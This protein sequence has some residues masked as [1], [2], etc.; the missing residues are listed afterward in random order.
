MSLFVRDEGLGA[1]GEASLEMR[2]D[3]AVVWLTGW[4]PAGLE[5]LARS[6]VRD[7]LES[8]ASLDLRDFNAFIESGRTLVLEGDV[9]LE[10]EVRRG[11][12]FLLRYGLRNSFFY[13]DERLW[14]RPEPRVF[15]QWQP[16]NKLDLTLSF[17]RMVQYLHLISNSS[18]RFPNDLWL[19]TSS[20]LRPQEAWQGE[21][22]F[23]WQIGPYWRWESEAYYKYL[24][25]LQAV[26]AGLDFVDAINLESPESFLVAGEGEATGIENMI[27][28]E[29]GKRSGFASYTLARTNRRF[30][31]ENLDQWF[32]Q[33][34]DR[35]HQFKLHY[36]QELS[37]RFRVGLNWVLFSANPF[38]ELL[39]VTQGVGLTTTA[40]P[41]PGQRNVFRSEVYHRLD[42][43]VAYEIKRPKWRQSITAGLYNAYNRRN[44]AYFRYDPATDTV[45]RVYSMGL[46]PAI[47]YQVQF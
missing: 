30:Q 7:G 19:P 26:P 29:R 46:R 31:G 47:S 43:D 15:A 39:T 40:Q 42:L 18:I 11:N 28:Y 14:V 33:D 8:G 22:G 38:I 9:Y 34:F 45:R 16:G 36:R 17:S 13:H 21:L 37:D 1:T 2:V 10:D 27:R 12:S 41:L 23:G 35:R 24:T 25:H 5:A 20:G 3:D 32:A 44:V 6:A 4:T